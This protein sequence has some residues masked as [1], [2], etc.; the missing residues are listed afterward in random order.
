MYFRSSSIPARFR[1]KLYFLVVTAIALSSLLPMAGQQIFAQGLP[2][3]NVELQESA[4]VE[5]VV[6][7][8][9]IVGILTILSI[10]PAIL[11]M[12]TSFTRILVVMSFVRQALGTPTMPPNQVIVGLSLFLTMFTMAPVWDVVQERA[13]TPYAE[14][15]LTRAR[16]SMSL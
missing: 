15:R 6:P 11:L 13:Y 9:K 7:A 8:M 12:M 14:R 1:Y 10:A 4:E 2:S 5:D 16:P 3:I